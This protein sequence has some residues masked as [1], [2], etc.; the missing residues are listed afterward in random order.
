MSPEP[1]G[2]ADR[3]GWDLAA[4]A[5]NEGLWYFDVARDV[6]RMSPRTLELLGYHDADAVSA[7]G[8]VRR[9]VEA[10]DL[11]MLQ[12]TIS[13]L[14]RGER[15][16]IDVELRLLTVGGESR[17]A[18][19]R[20]RARRGTDGRVTLIGGS[21]SDIDARKR[22]EM[23]LREDSRRDELTGL[24]NRAAL[25]EALTARIARL[26]RRPGQP[27]A[28]L[29]V[30]LDRFKLL[31]DTMGHA[32]GDALLLEMSERL[33]SAVSARDTVA[34]LGGDEFVILLNEVAGEADVLRTA[35][36]LHE[37]IRPRVSV[38]G[39]EVYITISVGGL[40]VR[41]TPAKASDVL[42]D[43][44]I[45]M[46]DAK[47]QG[48][49]RTM[50]F[51]E[52]MRRD[53]LRRLR[54]QTELHQA[55]RHRELRVAYQPIFDA[56]E[57]RLCGFEALMRW[58]HPTR[59]ALTAGDFVADANENGLI[60]PLGR[61]LLNEVCAQLA[62]WRR[63]HPRALPLTVA[64]N[65]CDRELADPDFAEGVEQALATHGI[66]PEC[67]V[68]EMTEGVMTANMEA[69]IPALK[70]LRTLGVQIQMD[71]FGSGSTSLATLRRM[72]LTAIKVD[73]SF[74]AGIADS[75]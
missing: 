44:D 30:D 55:L 11:P 46:Y 5:S 40:L 34:R 12:K 74:I 65:L 68:L 66:P 67:L 32:A 53:S 10:R 31:N 49:S 8:E 2:M 21:L 1:A 43:A 56:Q 57:R 71:D 17:W 7:A 26:A 38:S 29:F 59:G 64:V 23:Q 69:A 58:Q 75:E 61:W 73:Q 33:R 51:D 60:V 47:R 22:K 20:A 52:G 35:E 41:E 50:L 63:E 28:L 37:A 3:D 13:S 45:A 14:V 62:E 19:L 72:P 70:H 36:S 16:S 27:F 9:H 39:R 4:A 42:R 54:V 15:T 18:L 25:A 24:A 6:V 48:G